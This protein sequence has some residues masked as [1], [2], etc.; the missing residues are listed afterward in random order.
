MPETHPADITGTISLLYELA[1]SAGQSLDLEANCD[2]F[3]RTLLARKNLAF[4]AIWLKADVLAGPREAGRPT[5]EYR[6]AHANPRFRVRETTLAADH[7]LIRRLAAEPFFSAAAGE[8]GFESL[9]TEKGIAG[10]VF[11]V[12]ALG[13]VGFLKVYSL[14]R[15]TA[16]PRVELNTLS[17][18]LA[19]FAVSLEGCLA[20]RRLA[21]EIEE[22]DRA[23]NERRRLAM[24]VE[25]MEDC[26]IIT[27]AAGVFRYVNPAFER[28]TGY[29]AGEVAGLTPRILKSGRHPPAFYETL[30][31][32]IRAGRPWHDRVINRLKNGDLATFDAI[33]VP[34]REDQGGPA[35]FVAVLRDVTRLIEIEQQYAEAQKMESIGRLAGGMAHD[36]NNTLTAILGFGSLLLETSGEDDPDR[37]ALEQ[38]VLAGERAANLTRQLLTFS[39]PPMAELHVL[40]LNALV[41]NACHL[42]RRSLGEDVEL[43]TLLDEHSGSV[44]ADASLINQV[45]T[46]LSLN[47]RDAMP[48]GGRLTIRTVP[49]ELDTAFCSD[50]PGISPGRH[51]LLSVHDTGTGMT[52]DIRRR[53]FEPFFT[54]KGTGKGTGLGLSVV[55]GIVRR[56][57]G[58]IELDSRPEAGTEVR[59]WLPRTETRGDTLP[60]ELEEKLVGGSET[61]LVVED[62][63]MVRDLATR[64]LRS[65][66]YSLLEA[67]SGEEALSLLDHYRDRLDLVLTDVV[68]P[69]MNGVDLMLR[70]RQVRPGLK[71]VYMSGFADDAFA[72][73]GLDLDPRRLIRKPFTKETLA[74]TLRKVLDE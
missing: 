24:V 30:W 2:R 28:V 59:L 46:N 27:D 52:E 10:G 14:T 48:R 58:C 35:G 55:Y 73:R 54:T 20:H 1:L 32:T 42:L 43:V 36:F 64:L 71:V 33:I 70:L 65:L 63:A 51:V 62:E 15:K 19:K 25:Q 13:S 8:A 31:S 37:H 45:V 21:H 57:G 60:V 49:A 40:D 74:R 69:Q 3:L 38:I 18:V 61:I 23:E 17:Q 41:L 66:G 9:A 5:G 68:M 29:S 44:R 26:V 16:F 7:P 39:R 53:A 72:E 56:L 11:A 67:G 47:A 22:R 4:G 34:T 6:L 12:Y 50:H